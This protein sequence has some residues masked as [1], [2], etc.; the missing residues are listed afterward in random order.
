MPTS[1]VFGQL[2]WDCV[3]KAPS[4]ALQQKALPR[5]V[6]GR[7]RGSRVVQDHGL[8]ASSLNGFH[9]FIR[10]TS[11]AHY[12][13]GDALSAGISQ[14]RE[15]SQLPAW[16]AA[17]E[18][19]PGIPSGSSK[20]LA[21]QWPVH[22]LD[23]RLHCSKRLGTPGRQGRGGRPQALSTAA[24]WGHPLASELMTTP[25]CWRNGALRT[26]LRAYLI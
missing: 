19:L 6:T 10:Q 26:F 22:T 17:H 4:P 20:R 5:R 25:L 9:P 18:D 13:P 14:R 7:W 15:Q 12:V 21:V 2:K 24:P 16:G 1:E 11:R 23:M 8:S 3:R